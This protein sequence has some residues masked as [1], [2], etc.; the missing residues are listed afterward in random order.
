MK[1]LLALLLSFI[2]LG[3]GYFFL[4]IGQ[5]AELGNTH[6][7]LS[8]TLLGTALSGIALYVANAGMKGE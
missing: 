7:Q 4:Y 5:V 1:Q 3:F 8:C 2:V 6:D